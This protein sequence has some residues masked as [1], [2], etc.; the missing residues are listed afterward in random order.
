MGVPDYPDYE[1]EDGRSPSAAC[2]HGLEVPWVIFC[3]CHQAL[4]LT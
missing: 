4:K 1:S 2:G 3:V